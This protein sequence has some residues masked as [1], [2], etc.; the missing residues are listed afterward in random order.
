MN[1]FSNVRFSVMFVT[2]VSVLFLMNQINSLEDKFWRSL[3][4]TWQYD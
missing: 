4:K 1:L 3:K 2:V